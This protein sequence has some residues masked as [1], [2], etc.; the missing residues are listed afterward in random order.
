MNWNIKT[1]MILFFKPNVSSLL[2]TYIK[3]YQRDCRIYLDE[4]NDKNK[5]KEIYEQKRRKNN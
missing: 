5:L 1:P 3:I 4:Y 2:N